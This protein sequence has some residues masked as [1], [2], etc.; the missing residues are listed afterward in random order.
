MISKHI[1]SQIIVLIEFVLQE[2][3]IDKKSLAQG[4]L[5][6]SINLMICLYFM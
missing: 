6:T 2:P 5:S 3:Y 1:S 4:T